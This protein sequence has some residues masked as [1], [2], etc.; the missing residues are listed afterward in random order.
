MKYGYIYK[1]TCLVNGKIYIGKK[2]GDF[3]SNYFGSGTSLKNALKLYGTNNFKVEV[4][5]T[6]GTL[7]E[8]NSLEISYIRMYRCLFPREEM[9][10]IANGGD[11]GEMPQEAI[12]KIK[13][14]LTGKHQS[15][16]TR[17]RRSKS[18]LGKK[19]TLGKK[20]HSDET[21]EKLR[22]GF[23]ENNPAKTQDARK[24]I[25]ESR[26]GVKM[27]EDTK[28]KLRMINLGKKRIK[29]HDFSLN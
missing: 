17:V 9:Y 11:G 19:N 24:K 20:V 26:K 5:I 1:T 21:K 22:Q 7:I 15:I 28:L 12:Q 14:A 23:I 3:K 16:E 10:N 13:E 8:L 27:S 25:S 4:L 18:M 29:K 2:K 6:A